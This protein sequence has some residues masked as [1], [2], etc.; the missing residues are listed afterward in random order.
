MRIFDELS[1]II[2]YCNYVCV[3]ECSVNCP[4][5]KHYHQFDT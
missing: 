5:F 1:D 3:F 4:L 2:K